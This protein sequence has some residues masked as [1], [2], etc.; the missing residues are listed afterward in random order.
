MKLKNK[1]DEISEKEKEY[2]FLVNKYAKG[3]LNKEELSR[4][5]KIANELRG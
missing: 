4:I 3:R 5:N 1:K 2:L